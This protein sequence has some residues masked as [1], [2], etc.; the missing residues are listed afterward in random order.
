[1]TD[2]VFADPYDAATHEESSVE[3]NSDSDSHEEVDVGINYTVRHDGRVRA[4]AVY[5]E[6]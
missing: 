5:V 4:R 3:S 1:M 6:R 2:T